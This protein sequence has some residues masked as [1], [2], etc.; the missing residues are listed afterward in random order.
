[1]N[2]QPPAPV[3]TDAAADLLREALAAVT[4]PRREVYGNPED[5]FATIAA[6][7]RAYWYRRCKAGAHY[8]DF[9]P[10]DVGLMMSLVKVARLAQTPD[11]HDS[12]A[13]L[14]G[15]AGCIARCQK[16]SAP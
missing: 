9:T 16:A 10:T 12:A 14:A 2:K 3:E 8:T 1:M 6:L 13:D 5:N 15:F 4:G 7:W 11:H